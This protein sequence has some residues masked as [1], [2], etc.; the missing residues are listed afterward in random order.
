MCLVNTEVNSGNFI[1]QDKR[2]A[3]VDWEKA[4]ISCRYQDLAHFLVPTTTM[5]K[6]D[7]RFTPESRLSFL[8]Q[9]YDLIRPDFSFDALTFKTNILEQ[10]IL[11][12]A[13][14]WCYMAWYEY[15]GKERALSDPATFRKITVYLD[16]LACFLK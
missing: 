16:N 3:L 11:L 12:R 4:V 10:T 2:G 1:I 6:S 9:Y 14:S 7:F 15:T 5:W 13:M 8:R